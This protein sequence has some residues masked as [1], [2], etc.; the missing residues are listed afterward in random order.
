MGERRH[1]QRRGDG[2]IE[3][4]LFEP[5][6]SHGVLTPWPWV[7]T[8]RRSAGS[9]SDIRHIS[10]AMTHHSGGGSRQNCAAVRSSC[11]CRTRHRRLATR[12]AR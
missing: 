2:E 7:A 3:S 12:D 1:Q 8:A 4:F 11:F 5:S 10:G 9:G 6:G